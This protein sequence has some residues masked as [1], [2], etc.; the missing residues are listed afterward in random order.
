MTA[1]D[2]TSFSSRKIPVA[3]WAM[4]GDLGGLIQCH[5]RMHLEDSVEKDKTWK[6]KVKLRPDLY[7]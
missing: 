7:S 6:T 1:S 5:Y 3:D 4:A 2:E